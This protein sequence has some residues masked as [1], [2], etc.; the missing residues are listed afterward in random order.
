ML[1]PDGTEMNLHAYFDSIALEQDPVNRIQR[2]LNDTFRK[3]IEDKA[4]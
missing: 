2:P 4:K 3:T 1:T